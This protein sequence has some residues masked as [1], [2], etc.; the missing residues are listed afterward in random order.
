M[1]L[2]LPIDVG[3]LCLQFFGAYNSN[4]GNSLDTMSGHTFVVSDINSSSTITIG[5]DNLVSPTLDA[6][7]NSCACQGVGG[8]S[9]ATLECDPYTPP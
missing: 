1:A 2:P 6:G 7:S 4:I 8:G 3:R 9:C 5:G